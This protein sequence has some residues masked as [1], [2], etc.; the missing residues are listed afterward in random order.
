[1][2]AVACLRIMVGEELLFADEAT[3]ADLVAKV[4]SSY[5]D[6][7]WLWPRRYGLVAPF[8]FVLADPRVTLLDPRELQALAAEL[9]HKL[10]GEESA[11]EVTLLTLEGDQ[12]SVMQ[13]AGATRQAL[14]ALLSGE[15]EG[16]SARVCKIT[17]DEVTSIV[18]AGGSV[19]GDPPYETLDALSPPPARATFRGVYHLPKQRFVGSTLIWQSAGHDVRSGELRPAGAARVERDLAG[20]AAAEE[21]LAAMSAGRL[22]VP[23]SFS[24]LIKPSSRSALNAALQVL[25]KALRSRLAA[26]VYDTPRSPSFGGLTQVRKI[27]SPHFEVV[28]LCVTDPAFQIDYLPPDLARSVTLM[29]P[30]GGEKPRLNAI[31]AFFK[32]AA[33]YRRK[34]VLQGVT[35]VR[36]RRELGACL[37]L[38][39]PFVSGPAISDLMEEPVGGALAAES[40]LPLRAWHAAPQDAVIGRLAG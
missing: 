35:D 39:A 36:S 16:V 17:R 32:E 5:L 28:D 20:V 22:F 9:H 23:V 3:M 11:G 15:I 19:V 10:F 21:A 4:A 2:T 26:S 27:L 7:R 12:S 40:G 13:F 18:P 38:A 24:T 14:R 34:G 6:S 31:A 30:E 25:P 1:M 37:R 29:L 8:A 33:A